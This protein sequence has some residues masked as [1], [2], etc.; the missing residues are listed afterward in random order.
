MLFREAHATRDSVL[1]TTFLAFTL[2]AILLL[3]STSAAG[4]KGDASQPI[5]MSWDLT[6][7]GNHTL[8]GTVLDSGGICLDKVAGSLVVPTDDLQSG[9]FD[10]TSWDAENGVGLAKESEIRCLNINTD[11]ERSG[12]IYREKEPFQTFKFDCKRTLT[13]IWFAAGK[14]S[15]HIK[16]NLTVSI[17]TEHGVVLNSESLP[18]YHFDPWPRWKHIHPDCTLEANTTYRLVFSANVSNGYYYV[19]LGSG[20]FYENGSYFYNFTNDEDPASDTGYD[21]EL[22]IYCRNYMDTGLYISPI[23]NAGSKVF[24]KN[25]TWDGDIY[26]EQTDV[27]IKV[28]SG[29][30]TDPED[31]SFGEWTDI[32]NIT[33]LSPS[34]YIQL[35]AILFTQ[36]TN[37]TPTIETVEFGYTK[38]LKRGDV[39]VP[40]TVMS[41]NG[42]WSN[43]SFDADLG[44]QAAE[45]FF[46]IDSG[47]SWADVSTIDDNHIDSDR[48]RFFLIIT[49]QDTTVTPRL[50]G[51]SIDFTPPPPE[52]EEPPINDTPNETVPQNK[53]IPEDNVTE[54]INET[55]P[56]LNETLPDNNTLPEDELPDTNVTLPENNTL[57]DDVTNPVEEFTED[58]VFPD[59]TEGDEFEENIITEPPDTIPDD[60]GPRDSPIIPTPAEEPIVYVSTGTAVVSLGF[61]S[62]FLFTENGKYLAIKLS[63]MVIPLYTKLNKKKVLDHI[64]R[65]QIFKYIESNPGTSFSQIMK[66]LDV[67]NGA[68]VHHLRTL[69]RENFIKSVNDGVYYRRFYPIDMKLKKKEIN[70]LSW[71]QLGIYNNIRKSPGTTPKELSKELKKSKQVINYHIR[72]MKDAN[73]LRTEKDGK[74]TRLYVLE[75]RDDYEGVRI[76]SPTP[77]PAADGA[78][79]KSYQ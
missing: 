45:C 60:K 67:S 65:K 78:D 34:R 1:K 6:I 47:K 71:F 9:T 24:W 39:E 20:P 17:Q 48:I 56:D 62:A 25:M 64:Q 79:T 22:E 50:Y 46:S 66:E 73:L 42:T 51:L 59:D 3:V 41:G 23:F 31:G 21:M 68:L 55:V 19:K 27:Q 52:E 2:V 57:P 38:Y 26:P 11:W 58:L 69:E 43:F 37:L 35:N 44:G 13:K 75:A 70:H 32:Q 49:T 29:D 74:Q 33:S 36:D 54:P 53:T 15:H 28:R 12:T 63:F 8:N 77:A 40:G 16:T 30:S 14:S 10:N 5:T 72:L 7:P 4:Q 76:P 61:L 18:Y